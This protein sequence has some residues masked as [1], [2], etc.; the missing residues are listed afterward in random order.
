[1]KDGKVFIWMQL[2]G[3]NKDDEDKG[4]KRFLDQTGFI[5][6]GACGLVFHSDFFHHH[7]GM[8]EEYVLHPDNCSYYGIPRNIERERQEWTNYDLRELSKNLQKHGSKLYASIFGSLI[9]DKF[10]REWA[11]DNIEIRRHGIDGDGELDVL[12]RNLFC[13]KRLKDGSY[14]EDFF[15]EKVCQ[16]LSDYDLAGIHLG[17]G[18]CP[19]AA[20]MLSTIEYSTDYV[21]QFLQHSKVVLPDDIMATMGDDSAAAEQK[22]SAYIYRNLREEFVEFNAWRWEVFFK[23]LCSRVHA[24]GKEVMTLGM[25][26]TDPFETLYC[27]GIDMK[28]I[29]NAGVDCITANLVASSCAIA[30]PDRYPNHFHRFMAVAPTTAAFLPKGHLITMLAVQDATEEW[31]TIHHAPCMHERDMYTMMA[32]Q[33]CD[34]DGISRASDGYFICLGDGIPRSDWDWERERLEI[35]LSA[36]PSAVV[37]P[38][39]YWSD[40]AYD[41]TL[42][43][44]IHTRRWLPHKYF[45][46][47][48]KAGT[49]CS[50]CIRREGLNNYSG[51]LLVPNFDML[52]SDEQKDI[53]AYNKGAVFCTACPGFDP[54][55]YGIAAEFIFTDSYSAY[56]L[57]AFAFN[58]SLNEDIK[59]KV[60]ELLS[61]DD[62]TPNLEGDL[63][64][65]A[66]P[67]YTLFDTLTY[68]KV[69][70]GFVDAMRLVLEAVTE[71][72]FEID[73]PNITL[74][75][76][77]GA[78]RVFLYNDS[79]I[80][81]H[82]AFVKSKYE[83]ADVKIISKFPI[84]PP[85][86]MDVNTNEQVYL[87]TGKEVPKRAFEIKMQPAGVTIVDIY[88]K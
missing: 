72:P 64:N 5:P 71:S 82:R 81:Y 63:A 52:S 56:P 88:L 51:T 75:M 16:A 12:I 24:I 6:D 80:K 38:M 15:I 67:D 23:K 85:R 35:G 27:T 33:L 39:M 40:Y 13:L 17:D 30:N 18:F 46:E 3:F 86:F 14:Y 84:L 55:A 34:G 7:R 22:R 25:Y 83:M 11:S 31:S 54:S 70:R 42:H 43:E 87:Y 78:Y 8:D 29:V 37:S 53:A 79:E 68:S 44:Y 19:A 36:K 45:Y 9:G 4:A 76:P 77:D 73:K 59:S 65:V 28:R 2:L 47:F 61:V 50:G 32:Y 62:G 66:E 10:H 74:K 49:F 60:Y 57:T 1:M 58:C 20:K 48:T 26:C 69:T 21:D 41:H